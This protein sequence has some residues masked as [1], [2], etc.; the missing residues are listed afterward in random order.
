MFK[1]DDKPVRFDNPPFADARSGQVLWHYLTVS[2]LETFL[3][4]Q[5]LW[6]AR[7]TTFSDKLEGTFNYPALRAKCRWRTCGHFGSAPR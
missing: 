6:L 2:K 1:A 4:Q 5:A 7:S 3:V